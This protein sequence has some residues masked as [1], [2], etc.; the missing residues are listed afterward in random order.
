ME[1][2]KDNM[3]IV[4]VS[5]DGYSDLW[6]DFFTLKDLNWGN[7]PYNTYLA[8]NTKTFSHEN[9][10]V[11]N[12]GIDAQWSD[13]AR[14]AIQALSTKYV[15][16]MVEDFYISGPV[17][18]K[19]IEEALALMEKDGIKYYK[20]QTMTRKK[21]ENYEGID[22]LRTITSNIK[23]GVSLTTGIWEKEHILQLIGDESYNPWKFEAMRVLEASQVVKPYAVVGVFDNRN[24]L[25]ICH[26]VVQGKYIP[27]SVKELEKKGYKIVNK[28]RKFLNSKEA[29]VLKAK[30]ILYPIIRQS[31]IAVK[32]F[33][34]LPFKSVRTRNV[35]SL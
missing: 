10:T 11:I 9:V 23:Y 31:S 14:K 8:N 6:E 33:D 7:C 20:L 24:V 29:F 18:N 32:L 25:N 19:L 30:R 22:Y 17:D 21:T 3:S 34:V 35:A 26:M 16:L 12:C 4:I 28:S 27:S 2:L 13:R 5:Y 15:C 1:Q